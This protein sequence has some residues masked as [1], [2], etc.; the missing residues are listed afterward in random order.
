MQSTLPDNR[1]IQNI[2]RD[3]VEEYASRY[4]VACNMS[5]LFAVLDVKKTPF[6]EIFFFTLT[7]F[8]CIFMY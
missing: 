8:L 3:Y 6:S 1:T 5:V 4:P 2:V 7:S